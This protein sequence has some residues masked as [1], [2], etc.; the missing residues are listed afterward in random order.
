M[1]G[2][3]FAAAE[4][5]PPETESASASIDVPEISREQLQQRLGSSSVTVVDVLPAGSYAMG[6]IPGAISL[7]FEDIAAR[8]REVLPDLNAEIVTYCAKF[9]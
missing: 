9:T 5:M 7:P 8:A 2:T 4:E 3:V 1:G 6:H